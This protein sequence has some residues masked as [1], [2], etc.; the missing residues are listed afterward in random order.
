MNLKSQLIHTKAT[1]SRSFF[2]FTVGRRLCDEK[3]LNSL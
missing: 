3:V 2:V 1:H